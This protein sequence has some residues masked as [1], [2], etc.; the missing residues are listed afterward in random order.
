MS[1]EA[2]NNGL[3]CVGGIGAKLEE[4]EFYTEGTKNTVPE[5]KGP[6]G[7]GP[8]DGLDDTPASRG[9][10]FGPCRRLRRVRCR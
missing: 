2:G 9:V 4:K 5:R 1:R 8:T 6:A 3:S 7:V 10:R